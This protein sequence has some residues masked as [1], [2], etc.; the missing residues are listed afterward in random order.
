MR[1]YLQLTRAHTVPL[2]AVP[3]VIG[4]ALAVGTL[5]HPSVLIW[6]VYGVLYHLAGYGMNSYVDWRK[7]F[8][9][10]DDNKS[11]H[12]LNSGDMAEG[13]AKFV[14]R[15]LFISTALW[16]VVFASSSLSAVVVLGFGVV[17]GVS[18]N[19]Y[20]KTTALKPALISVA[21]TTVFS[22]PY[23]ASGGSITDLEFI[24]GSVYVLMWVFFQIAISGEMKDLETDEVNLLKRWG[25]AKHLF[26]VSIPWKILWASAV[27]KFLSFIPLFVLVYIYGS[28]PAL[29][30]IMMLL[31]V[32]AILF[33]E[34]MLTGSFYIREEKLRDMALIEMV[35]VFGLITATIPV[36]SVLGGLALITTSV[37]W[38]MSFNYIEWGT[39][40]SPKV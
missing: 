29:I 34:N 24:L 15:I 16:A 31:S 25:L 4:S 40:V 32:L 23:L 5:Y 33:T 21:H 11:H 37:L 38:V 39:Y 10:N 6:G 18:Y 22:V 9:R 26:N 19:Y 17:C 28:N 1:K 30:F 36:I 20:G 27:F 3:A 12:P 8:D 7:G 35:M 14:V 2:E 13:E